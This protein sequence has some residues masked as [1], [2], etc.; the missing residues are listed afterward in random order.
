[1]FANL[2][3]LAD[4]NFSFWIDAVKSNNKIIACAFE[5]EKEK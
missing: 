2:N 5:H 4:A 3:G 1:M